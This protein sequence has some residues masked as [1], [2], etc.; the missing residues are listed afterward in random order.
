MRF[1]AAILVLLLSTA[2]AV[3]NDDWPAVRE[4]SL[5]LT[6]GSPLDFSA[7][8]PNPP[9]DENTRI[10][11]TPDG[12]LARADAMATPV[13]FLCASLAWSP[14]SGGFPDHDGA[15]RYAAQLRMH[16]YNIARFHF[17]DASLMAGRSRDFDFNPDILDRFRYLMAAL[18][19]NGIYWIID[20]MSSSRG[21]LGGYDDRWDANG[22]MKLDVKIDDAAFAHW[23]RLQRDILGTINPYTRVAPI[24]DPALVMIV[25]V[26]ENGIEFDSIAHE[27]A[28]Q[29]LYSPKLQGPF[30]AWLRPRYGSS[31]ALTKAWGRI[32]VGQSLEAG[33]IGLPTDR[34]ERS[35]RMRDLQA[36]FIDV[37][38]RSARR[39]E[40][41]LRDL[42]FRG[43]VAPY[44]NW[45]TIQTSLTRES[46]QAVAMNTYE[47]WIRSYD[48]LNKIQGTS[49]LTDGLAYIRSIAAARWLGKPFVVTEYDHLFWNPYRY[50]AG[51]A[52]PAYAAVQRWDIICRH[53]H[54][55]IVLAYGEASLHKRQMLPYAIALD[56]VARAGETLSALLFRRGDVKGSAVSIALAVRPADGP[57][58]SIQA[59]EPDALTGLA[60]IGALGLK[61]NEPSAG[62]D[63]AADVTVPVRRADASIP[64][65]LSVLRRKGHGDQTSNGS[66][67]ISDTGQV[68]L[69][70][71]KRQATVRTDTT[72]AI[73]FD[74]LDG[75]VALGAVSV[76]KATGKGLFALSALDSK[77]ISQ[78]RRLLVIFATD[79]HNTGMRFADTNERVIADYGWLPVRIRPET[80][81]FS[82]PGRGRWRLSPIGLDGMVRSPVAEGTG[83]I[84][85][86]LSNVTPAGP[87]TY[88][89]IE[90]TP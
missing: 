45:P 26:N 25:P 69:D 27:R 49:S 77:T 18:K 71:D 7:V 50:E 37:E 59:R 57:G 23:L 28:G 87:T 42:G 64:G 30:N 20:G 60:L 13:R 53:A 5:E 17:I 31:D 48:P 33:T 1:P 62:P 74:Q 47:D 36:F 67:V 12:H 9:I 63:P 82:M 51:L 55:P 61:R 6:P 8:L 32:A 66:I 68:A 65:I 83:D 58:E 84:V 78:S 43:I 89:L 81:D 46:Q 29:P 34:S 41:A 40:Q 54:G 35:P 85:A 2:P 86:S 38:V 76:N 39:M 10:S 73:A 44:N 19:R 52:M 11:V 70:R 24:R 79:A 80:I 88:F 16:G 21:G 15:D 4:I 14:A 75:P 90:K 22:D 3:A 56:P 72:Q